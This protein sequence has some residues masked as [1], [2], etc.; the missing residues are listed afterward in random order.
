MIFRTRGGRGYNKSASYSAGYYSGHGQNAGWRGPHTVRRG[1]HY[2]DRQR[3]SGSFSGQ[4]Y[5]AKKPT[6]R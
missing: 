6:Q 5:H 3:G 1:N 4:G 2:N